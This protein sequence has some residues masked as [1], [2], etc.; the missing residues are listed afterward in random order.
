VT[1]RLEA[2]ESELFK[3]IQMAEGEETFFGLGS[4]LGQAANAGLQFAEIGMPY[5]EVGAQVA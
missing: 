4:D 5:G 2:L 1:V 3:L